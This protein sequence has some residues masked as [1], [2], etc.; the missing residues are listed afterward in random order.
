MKRI[1][2]VVTKAAPL[3]LATETGPPSIITTSKFSLLSSMT[4]LVSSVEQSAI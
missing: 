2:G 3:F 1:Y 4:F